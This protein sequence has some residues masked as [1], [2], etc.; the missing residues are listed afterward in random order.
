MLQLDQLA[1]V[2]ASVSRDKILPLIAADEQLNANQVCRRLGL[3]ITKVR[4][5]RSGLL[6]LTRTGHLIECVSVSFLGLRKA[7]PTYRVVC[8]PAE[9]PADNDGLQDT[10]AKRTVRCGVD[11]LTTASASSLL[12]LCFRSV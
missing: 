1:K 5:V 12:F 11:F 10:S 6:H 4:R 2:L 9:A 8:A 7:T 3:P